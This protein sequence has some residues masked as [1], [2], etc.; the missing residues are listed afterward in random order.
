MKLHPGLNT[1][2]IGADEVRA[3]RVFKVVVKG[4]TPNS[5][6]TSSLTLRGVHPRR[7]GGV[8]TVVGHAWA[9]GGAAFP[10]SRDQGGQGH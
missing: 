3:S 5:L 8:Q 4:Q 6:L 7:G 10:E 9:Y 1:L 2:H